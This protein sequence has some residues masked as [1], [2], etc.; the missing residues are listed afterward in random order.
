[1]LSSLS[2]QDKVVVVTGATKGLGYGMAHGLADAGANLVIVSRSQD[3][4]EE[5]A[6]E[7]EKKGC[8]VLPKSADM[9]ELDSID[10]L[11]DEAVRQFGRIDVLVNNAGTAVTKPPEKMTEEDWDFVLD[12]NL[13]GAFFT[14]QRVGNQMIKQEHGKIIN[15]ASV[16]GFAGD[17]NVVSYCASKGGL[18]LMTKSLAIAWARHNIQ[19]NAIAPGYV[20][21]EMNS[22]VLNQEKVFKHLMNNTPMKRLG[23]VEDVVGAVVFMSSPASDFMT[24]ETVVIDGGWLA[25]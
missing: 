20:E 4:C 13:K 21:T 24:G 3:D 14:A 1:M 9:R 25:R 22:D 10:A 8:R 15:V 5:V 19:V 12:L 16:F 2:V 6:L 17:G 7:I 11:V 23:Q 18:I